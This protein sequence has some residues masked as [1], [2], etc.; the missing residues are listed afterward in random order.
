MC[1]VIVRRPGA[2]PLAVMSCLRQVPCAAVGRHREAFLPVNTPAVNVPC[3]R[4]Q[5]VFGLEALVKCLFSLG[6]AKVLVDY[7]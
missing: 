3:S 5:T 7:L 6:I 1:S 2:S 4:F